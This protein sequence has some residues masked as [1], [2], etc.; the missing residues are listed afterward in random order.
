MEGYMSKKLFIAILIFTH[1]TSALYGAFPESW[2]EAQEELEKIK[3]PVL[4]FWHA[5]LKNFSFQ[6]SH[7]QKYPGRTALAQFCYEHP[8]LSSVAINAVGFSVLKRYTNHV[9]RNAKGSFGTRPYISTALGALGINNISHDYLRNTNTPHYM[10]P[11][12]TRCTPECN[13][14][15]Q[16]LHD[17]VFNK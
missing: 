7:A 11:F 5:T 14:T 10:S 16:D 15:N 1:A 9:F 12:V 2:Q 13:N 17:A 3:K 4:R 8:I 6:Q